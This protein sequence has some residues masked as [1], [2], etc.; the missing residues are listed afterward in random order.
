MRRILLDLILI[1]SV[2]V[3]GFAK[4][5]KDNTKPYQPRPIHLDRDGE[6]WAEKTLHKLSVEQKVGQLFMIWVRAQFLNV[7]SPDYLQLRD[8][9][10]KYHIGSFCMT[11]PYNPPF[12]SKSEPY[13][14]AVLLNSLQQESSLPLLVAADFERGITMRLQ[15]GSIFPTAMAFGAAGKLD[16]AEGFGRISAQESRAVGV[17]WNFFPVAD[18]NSNPA[19]PI[20]NTRS[21]GE[22]PQLVGDMVAAYIRGARANGMLTTVKHFPGHGDTATD[23]HLGVAQV[24]GDLARLQSVE[25]RPFRQAIE[26]GVDSVM[27]AHVSVPALDPDPNHVATVSPAMVT[28]LLK[29][30]LGFK[31]IVVTDAL[32]MAGITSLYASNVGRAAVD[33]FKAGNDV[34]LIPADLESSYRAVLEAVLS[35]EIPQAR[36]DASVLKLL[37]AKAS[38]GLAKSRF[39]DLDSLTT[40]V[41]K[42]ENLALGQQISDDSVTVVRDNGK[43]LPLKKVGT[44]AASL[45]YQRVEQVHDR[46]VVVVF[47]EDVRTEAGRTL[48]NQIRSRVPDVR[49]IYVDPRIAGAMSNEVL[50]TVD[51]AQALIAAVYVVPTAGKA[52]KVENGAIKN[53]VGLADA[54][55]SLLQAVLDHAAEKT[56]VLAMGNPYLAQDFPSVQNY[57]CTFSNASVSEVSAAKALFGEIPI[58]GRL[59]VSI[60]NIAQRGSGMDRPQQVAG[61]NS[62]HASSEV[63]KH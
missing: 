40:M 45:P 43:V 54:S 31:G 13:E 36:L 39:V 24:T 53:S 3:P 5:R 22:D 63:G 28:G 37:K 23:S 21:F 14:A 44:L 15:G 49:V 27:V 20:I 17:H 11:V 12:L 19:N 50:R 55:A 47:S 18:V 38:L 10:R 2:L 29:N 60:P 4:D 42:K 62:H 59:P 57:I 61:G 16:Y 58:R 41:G 1:F 48:E 26:A 32:E 51:Q 25:L 56:A 34:L 52:A 7:D 9:I 46:L 30:Q 33:A 8:D 35:G 6:K